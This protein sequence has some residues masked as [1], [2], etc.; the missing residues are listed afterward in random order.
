MNV[1]EAYLWEQTNE[2]L[3]GIRDSLKKLEDNLEKLKW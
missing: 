3:K 1:Q 2:I